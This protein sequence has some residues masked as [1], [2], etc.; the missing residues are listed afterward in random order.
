VNIVERPG[1]ARVGRFD[2]I[3]HARLDELAMAVDH[4]YRA[5]L[6]TYDET[7]N[8]A[9]VESMFAIRYGYRV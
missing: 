2:A 5:C 1:V 8:T 6:I 4:Q 9:S 3:P 7:L